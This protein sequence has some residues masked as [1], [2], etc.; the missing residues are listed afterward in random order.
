MSSLVKVPAYCLGIHFIVDVVA[1]THL[2]TKPV[3]NMY[4]KTFI[5]ANNTNMS[6]HT[7]TYIHI[8]T[9]AHSGAYHRSKYV[10]DS[11]YRFRNNITF[12]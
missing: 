11:N 8:C 6:M 7:H 12:L 5:Q 4:H 10:A 3:S 1:S 9:H 2:K